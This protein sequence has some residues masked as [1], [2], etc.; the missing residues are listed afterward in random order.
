MQKLLGGVEKTH[1][2]DLQMQLV[3]AEAVGEHTHSSGF[4]GEHRLQTQDE[5]DKTGVAHPKAYVQGPPGSSP[6][7]LDS[8][9]TA[10]QPP[11]LFPAGSQ[12]MQLV[13]LQPQTTTGGKWQTIVSAP[14]T[15]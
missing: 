8:T 4:D 12:Q 9:A 10:G 1:T 15:G 3:S 11:Q 5:V 14:A 13:Q 2:S 7:K 6:V